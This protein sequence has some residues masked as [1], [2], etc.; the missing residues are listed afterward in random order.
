MD[1]NRTIGA[2]AP[3][4]HRIIRGLVALGVFS[5]GDDGRFGLTALGACLQRETPGSLHTAAIVWGEQFVGA[6]GGLLH[7]VLTGETAFNHVFG[8]SIW[9]IWPQH[10]E[11]NQLMVQAT[12]QVAA[13]VLA[14]YDFSSHSI[15]ADVGGGSEAADFR[16]QGVAQVPPRKRRQLLAEGNRSGACG[17]GEGRQPPQQTERRCPE[18]PEPSRG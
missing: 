4:L 9:E 10:P 18:R 14:V 17:G 6:W 15:I 8:R 12:T 2:H 1:K 7:S 5:E 3:S 11:C 16:S 13:A